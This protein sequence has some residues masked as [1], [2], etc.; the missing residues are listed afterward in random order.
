MEIQPLAA[1]EACLFAA[2]EPVEPDILAE[3]LDLRVSE[4]EE[5][6]SQLSERYEAEESGVRLM[7]P[8]GRIQVRTKSEYAFFV[9]RLLEPEEGNLSPAALEVLALVAYRQP[10]TRPEVDEFRG[11]QSSHLLRRLQAEG[12]VIDVGRMDVPGRPKMYG[13]TDRFLEQFGLESLE[14]LPPLPES[15]DASEKAGE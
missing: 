6:I 8:G 5:L 1:L 11:V 14:D 12:L 9:G 2:P 7:R 15:V 3:V 10:I 13:T 4:V